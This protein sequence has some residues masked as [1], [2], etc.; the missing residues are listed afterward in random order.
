MK[1]KMRRHL[2]GKF[3]AQELAPGA[4]RLSRGGPQAADIFLQGADSRGAG[5]LRS[6]DLADL[7]IEWQDAAVEL[8]LWAGGRRTS[9]LGRSAIVHEPLTQLYAALP[10]VTL[11]AKARRFWRRVFLLV[12]IPGG[13]FLL[14]AMARRTRQ[15]R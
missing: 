9:V 2:P 13:R 14:G 4:W 1:P 15:R 6:S 10:L 7:D 5:A 11:N 8:T 3:R 12:R